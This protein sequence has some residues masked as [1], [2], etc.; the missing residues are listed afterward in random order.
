MKSGFISFIGRPNVGKSTLLNSILGTKLAI[1]S[2]KPQTT[3]DSIQG[4]YTEG[5]IQLVFIDTP[6]IH[7]PKTKLGKYINKEAYNNM[8][9]TSLLALVV[10]VTEPFGKG[11]EFVL[12]KIKESNVPT[13][14]V[15]N[16]V[17]KIKREEVLP[18]IEEY[19]NRYPFE[20]IVP[21]SALK[22]ENIKELIQVM[23]EYAT[24]EF[25][26]YDENTL[27]NKNMNYLMT[28]RIREKIFRLTDEEVP[29]ST[30]VIIE[31]MEKKRNAYYI[32]ANVIVD[33]DAVKKIIIGKHGDKIKQIGIEARKEIEELLNAKVYLEIFVKTVKKWRDNEKYL[34]EF[35]YEKD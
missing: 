23:K 21:I 35:G 31:H 7:K 10:D 28:E 8:M 18:I 11:D 13:I 27:T 16:K 26:Y 2:S 9:D 25:W 14:L 1:T 17:D 12:E 34:T 33:R 32:I 5:D 29:Y 6:G 24:E 22:K 15:L 3:R 30:A 20:H 4:V 19:Q